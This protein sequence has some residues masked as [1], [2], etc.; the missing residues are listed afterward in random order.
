VPELLQ[1]RGRACGAHEVGLERQVAVDHEPARFTVHFEAILLD[2]AQTEERLRQKPAR[3]AELDHRGVVLGAMRVQRRGHLVHLAPE[4]EAHE[5]YVVWCEIEQHAAPVK[6]R[7]APRQVVPRYGREHGTCRYQRA[8]LPRVQSTLRLAIERV[9]AVVEPHHPDHVGA[10]PGFQHLP[11]VVQRRGERFLQIDVLAL[12]Q[13]GECRLGVE[14]VREADD[15]RIELRDREQL[16]IALE[17]GGGR[18]LRR[19]RSRRA[20]STSA[21]ATSSTPLRRRR[22]SR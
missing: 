22:M 17:G 2:C 4:E 7:P 12:P 11:G 18:Y 13:R 6:A 1:P 5:V 10:L 9:E 8:E 3:E 14:R 20:G 16:L 21:R 19:A 15:D